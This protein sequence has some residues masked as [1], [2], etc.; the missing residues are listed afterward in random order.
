MWRAIVSIAPHFVFAIELSIFV[1]KRLNL[2]HIFAQTFGVV[3]VY[4]GSHITKYLTDNKVS[5]KENIMIF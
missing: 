2:V 4:I 1:H 5:T 3:N